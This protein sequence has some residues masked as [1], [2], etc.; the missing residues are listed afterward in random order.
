M[1]SFKKV[2]VLIL[3]LSFVFSLTACNLFGGGGT[4]GGGTGD[5][6]TGGQGTGGGATG[7][8]LTPSKDITPLAELMDYGSRQSSYGKPG[9]S[10]NASDKTYTAQSCTTQLTKLQD[11]IDQK[12]EDVINRDSTSSFVKIFAMSTAEELLEQ[13]AEAAL[14]FEEMDRVVNYLAGTV[15]AD[16]SEYIV[17]EANG[18]WSG[19]FTDGSTG[20]RDKTDGSGKA[21]N[22][23][24]SF[25]DDWEMYDRLKTFA[26]DENC[27]NKDLASDNAAWHYRS[28]LAKVYTEVKLDGDAAARMAVY[29]L[30]YGVEIVEN[31]SNGLAEDAIVDSGGETTYGQF[32]VYCK[33][34]PNDTDPFSG[35]ADYETL[36]YLL[37]FNKYYASGDGLQDCVTLYGYYYDYNKT[38]YNESL[39]DEDTYAKQLKYE[40]M[41]IFTNEEWLDY[42]S[43]QRHN[44]I[45]AY[46]YDVDFYNDFYDNHFEF[47][48]IIELYDEDVYAMNSVA[49]E[50]ALTRAGTTYTEQMKKA[51]TISSDALNGLEGQLAMSDWMWC[52]AGSED[53]MKSYNEANTKYQEGKE[54]S[55]EEEY[56]GRFYYELE[57]LKIINYLFNNMTDNELSSALYYQVYAYSASMVNIIQNDL[58][59]IV[60]IRDELENGA[61]YTQIA[62]NLND[63]QEDEYA[64]G[65][66]SVLY[67]QGRSSWYKTGVSNLASNAKSQNWADMETEIKVALEYDYMNMEI[68]KKSETW[69]ERVERLE[70]LVIAKQYSC[71]GQRV[72]EADVTKCDTGHVENADGT[73]ATKDYATD[74]TISQFV[75]AYEKVLYHIAGQATVSFQ[76]GTTK[77]GNAFSGYA[78]AQNENST[79]IAGYNGTIKDLISIA[80]ENMTYTEDEAFTISSGEDFIE[81]IDGENKD[82]WLARKEPGDDGNKYG[83]FINSEIHGGTTLQYKYTYTFKGWYLD[84]ECRYEFSDEDEVQTNLIVYAGYDV[85]KNKVN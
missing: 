46:R 1:K 57:E 21:F 68:I 52:Y 12:H 73:M 83:P 35:L 56:E 54:G 23:G 22:N 66:I 47:Q 59:D 40:K 20:W 84:K 48:S 44:Y 60:Y 30:D 67:E 38:Y 34:L 33:K 82:W 5:G 64:I 43:I 9:V 63:G 61:H 10:F 42:V 77:S 53:N 19:V 32:A 37:A 14:S 72:S 29:M 26:D 76:K 6:G 45:K 11:R 36:S 7:A 28:I 50:L 70:D 71:C 4:G 27:D 49:T 39:A 25:F 18:T 3:V 80:S 8:N 75:S 16:L 81:S 13:M 31:K 85:A 78:T 65:K 79:W 55:S 2:L 41:E 15:D 24:W 17:E 74:H 62:K 69:K 58:K 51:V